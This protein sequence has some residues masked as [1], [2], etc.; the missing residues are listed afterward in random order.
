MGL[1]YALF[2]YSLSN[3][4]MQDLPNHLTRAHIIADLLFNHGATYG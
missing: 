3:C 2:A 1:F 4:P